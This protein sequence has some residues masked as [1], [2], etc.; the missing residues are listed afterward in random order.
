MIPKPAHL[1]PQYGAQFSDQR[2]VD[3]YGTRPPYPAEVFAVLLDLIR[4]TP[5]AVLDAGCGRGEMARHLVAHVDRVDAVD[6]SAAMLRAGRALPGGDDPRLHWI[7]GPLETAP[8]T[9]PYALVVAAAS[10][11]WMDWDVVLPRIER[12]LTPQGV[13][14][15]VGNGSEP[16]PWQADLQV[17]IDRYSTNRDYRPYNLLDEL[18]R[19]N[20]F[21]PAGVQTIGPLPFTQS[22]AAYIESFHP[23]NRF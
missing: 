18:A 1:G 13:L 6:L 5:R 15:V 7:E 14:A 9:P 16:L 8:L 3:A 23:P 2:V 22:L 17:L 19:R 10:L 12:A 21:H 11:H 20:L 4:D